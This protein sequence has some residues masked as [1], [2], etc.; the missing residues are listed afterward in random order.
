MELV[1][2]SPHQKKRRITWKKEGLVQTFLEACLHEMIKNGR[3]GSSLKAQSWKNV[4]EQLRKKH[5]FIVDQR[6]MKNHYDY[7]KG[8]YTAFQKLKN[9][10]GNVYDPTTNTFNLTE[11]EWKIEISGNKYMEPLRSTGLL[12]PDLCVQLF[13]GV[14]SIGLESYGTAS[15]IPDPYDSDPNLNEDVEGVPETQ[16]TEGAATTQETGGRTST[17]EC[18]SRPPVQSRKRKGKEA[19]NSNKAQV[20]ET[21]LKVMNVMLEK[22]G[23]S[24]NDIDDCLKKLA[25]LGWDAPLHN[26]ALF[27]LSESADYRKMWM[28]LEPANCEGWIRLTARKLNSCLLESYEEL[29]LVLIIYWYW[30]YVHS[31]R[32]ECIRD[33]NSALTGHAYTLELLKGSNTQCVEL[34]RMSREAYILLC[35]HFK[36]KN[37]LQD[38][39]NITV[40]EKI[41]IFC[42]IIGHNERYRMVKRRFP[43]STETIHRYFREVLRAMMKFAKE[44]IRPTSFEETHNTLECQRNL[45][46][47]FPGAIGAL[48]GTLIHAIVPVDQQARCRGRG[49][50]ECY[51]NVLGICDFNMLFTYVWV[52]WEGIAHDARVL[53]EVAFSPTSGFPFPPRDKYY[54][55]DAAYANTR[56][57][58]TPYRNTRYWL[59][60]FRRQRALTKKKRKVQPCSCTTQKCIE[61]AYGVLKAR[62]PILKQMAPYPFRIQR[63]VAIACFAV[64]NFIR[65]CNIHDQLFMDFDNDPMFIAEGQE[66]IEGGDE[67][68]MDGRPYGSQNNEYMANLRDQIANQL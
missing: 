49:K 5:N 28:H 57:F 29:L 61:R 35:N 25:E 48:D 10:T 47:I 1:G 53:R 52:G 12:F 55:W 8:K 34:M 58:M 62:F 41:A 16:D 3:E 37:W 22:H 42:T 24:T 44:V 36:Q 15:T 65:R 7:I 40:E 4:G 64:H 45:R 60:D 33:N 31:P 18:S 26:M 32:I 51:Q 13:D 56:G 38:S 9:K 46:R 30:K 14:A 19:C 66:E 20:E 2:E 63:N 23:A 43:H 67:D 39:R 21:I 6:Q 27:V 59:A 11:E 54:L 50:G 17:Q 68:D